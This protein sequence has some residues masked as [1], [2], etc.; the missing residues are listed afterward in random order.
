MSGMLWLGVLEESWFC[1]CRR[2]VVICSTG[3]AYDSMFVP[4]LDEEFL[5]V[6]SQVPI[7]RSGLNQPMSPLAPG[8]STEPH[9]PTLMSSPAA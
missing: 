2:R 8:Q 6:A 1:R 3:G 4:D 7:D 9:A 5:A